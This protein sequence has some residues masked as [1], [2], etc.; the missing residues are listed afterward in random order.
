[1]S[2]G[3]RKEVEELIAA[4]ERHDWVVLRKTRGVQLLAPDKKTVC[5]AH[6]T[7][8]DHRSIKNLR[9]FLKRHG[10]DVS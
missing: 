9:A 3:R 4:A 5:H 10:V 7:L 2:K 1:M 8:S 6:F